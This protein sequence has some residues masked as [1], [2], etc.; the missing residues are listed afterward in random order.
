MNVAILLLAS[1]A[2]AAAAP[3][4]GGQAQAGARVTAL[5]TV[6][7]LPSATT[8]DAPQDRSLQRHRRTSAGGAITFE[9]E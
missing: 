6:E 1:Q 8:R 4:S 3:V 5:A 9:F 7:I 2:L